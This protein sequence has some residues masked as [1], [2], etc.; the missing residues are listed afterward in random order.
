MNGVGRLDVA[1]DQRDAVHGI[2]EIAACEVL[3]ERG[4]R[5]EQADTETL[6]GTI[7]LEDHRIAETP[8]RVRDVV[9]A[10]DRQGLRR[11]DAEFGER[12][13]LRDLGEF[14][15]QRALAV[16]HDGAV[17]LEPGQHRA[18]QFGRI[19]MIAGVRRRAHAIVEDAGRR[20]RA[21]VEN[22]L[23][24]MPF[25]KR[26]AARG[27]IL[28]QRHDPLVILVNDVDLGR[29]ILRRKALAHEFRPASGK[30]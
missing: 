4:G 1:L 22:A 30:S 25:G 8:R 5:E 17:A 12:F 21:Q 2:L 9:L 24:E 26:N 20:R 18:G 16:D 7:V 14:E 27:E 29:A 23:I 15:L 19:A 10:D 28:P 11:F 3:F 6:A 13:V